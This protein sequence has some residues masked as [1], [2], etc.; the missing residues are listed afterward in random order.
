MKTPA[1]HNKN[2]ENVDLGG[3]ASIYIYIYIYIYVNV[4]AFFVVSL[5]GAHI[6]MEVCSPDQN[7]RATVKR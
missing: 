7:E 3:G 1:S 4:G 2:H 5:T 6:L